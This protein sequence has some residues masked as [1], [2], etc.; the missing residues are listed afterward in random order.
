MASVTSI[1]IQTGGGPY[2][3][4]PTVTVALPD[5]DSAAA[6]ITAELDSNGRVSSLNLISVG[7]YYS[8]SEIVT[9]SDPDELKKPVKFIPNLINDAVD[10]LT[11]DSSGSYY[12]TPPTIIFSEPTGVPTPAR[13]AVTL[14]DSGYVSSINIVDSGLYYEIVP[15][16]RLNYYVGDS[17]FFTSLNVTVNDSKV[18]SLSIPS[19]DP[20]LTT[21]VDSAEIVIDPQTGVASSFRATATTLISQGRVTDYNITFR[22]AGYVTPPTIAV[23]APTGDPANFKPVATLTVAN[24]VVEAVNLVDS[25]YFYETAPTVTAQAGFAPKENFRATATC[26]INALGQVNSITVTDGGLFYNTAPS[27][28]FSQPPQQLNFQIGESVEQQLPSGV[29]IRGEVADWSN[30]IFK[31]GV[32]HA[33][34]DD[35]KYHEFV[36]DVLITGQTSGA[37][38]NIQSIIEDN[39]LSAGEQNSDFSTEAADFLDFTESNP[40]GD[41]ENN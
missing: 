30:S 5:A 29:V 40:F 39:Q 28:T 19:G 24:G 22:G 3:T 1:S 25:G 8:G 10:N 27:V 34:A 15:I 38:G 14:N 36:S 20:I 7:T 11:I 2:D 17:A 23:E 37:R 26:T 21:A 33:G 32:I 12:I 13:G 35:G 41:P 9:F 31:L 16:A 6:T 4:A 18:S